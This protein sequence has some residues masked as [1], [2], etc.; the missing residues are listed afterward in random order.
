LRAGD[1]L[2]LRELQTQSHEMN[3]CSDALHT[4]QVSVQ[5]QES[6]TIDFE[7]DTNATLVTDASTNQTSSDS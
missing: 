1:E 5:E 7:A 4:S 3:G 2:F 6:G